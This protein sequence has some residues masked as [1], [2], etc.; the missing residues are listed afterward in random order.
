MAFQAP[1]SPTAHAFAQ[2]QFAHVTNF[3][4]QGRP[5]RFRLEVLPGGKAELNLTFQLPPA[6]EVIPPPYHV[7]PVPRQR[8]ILPLF[9]H[10]CFPQGSGGGNSKTKKTLKK[11]SSRLRKS[12]QRSVLHRAALSA[13]SLPPPKNGSLR[14]AALAC[15]QQLQG[16]AA[17]PV[18]TQSA[19]KR[20]LPVSPNTPSPSH[21]PPLAQRIRS[22]FQIGEGEVE[23]PERELLRSQPDLQNSKSPHYVRGVPPPAPLVFTPPKSLTLSCVNCD[24]EMTP[25]HQCK[26]EEPTEGAVEDSALEEG[27]AVGKSDQEDVEKPH[28]LSDDQHIPHEMDSHWCL[29]QCSEEFRMRWTQRIEKRTDDWALKSRIL[30]SLEVAYCTPVCVLSNEDLKAV[31]GPLK[32]QFVDGVLTPVQFLDKLQSLPCHKCRCFE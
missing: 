32:D 18:S 20:P 12:Y 31:M 6:S 17:S 13:P 3:W 26:L 2:H 4:K 22:D 23:S 28:T 15:V 1:W 9:P 24:T 7:S 14:Q 10:G 11:S 27:A 19:N 16:A 21:L 8:P 5:A 25:D 30:E 29:D